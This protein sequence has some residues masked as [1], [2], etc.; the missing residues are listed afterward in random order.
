MNRRITDTGVAGLDLHEGR[1]ELLEEIMSMTEQETPDVP[2]LAERRGRRHQW[3]SAAAAAAAVAAV[4]GGVVWLGDQ[5]QDDRV[6][7]APADGGFGSGDRAVLD[8]S[9]WELDNLQDDPEYGGEVDYVKGDQQLSVHWRLAADYDDYVADRNEIGASEQVDLLGKTS[10]LW[11]YSATDHT[12]IRPVEG[13]YTLEVRGSGMDE[14]AF[15]ALL[16]DLVLVDEDGLEE[17]LPDEAIL[18][19]ERPAAVTELLDEL[20]LPEG[21]DSD[22][23]ASHE[24]S[25][26]HLVA[27]VTGAVTCA[28]VE[29]FDA[30]RKAHDTAAVRAAQDALR[31]AR[32]WP[33]LQEIVDQGDWSEAVWDYADIVVAGAPTAEDRKILGGVEEGLGCD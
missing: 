24:L 15:R 20:P 27:D 25:R 9:G 33:M 26:Y 5:R 29:Q 8:Q 16:D 18:D 12:V 17:R 7:P 32:D 6:E 31:T 10:L 19:A 11:A 4:V 28:W 14:A 1:A 30:G 3:L 23:L 22:G 2:D 21:F 13:D